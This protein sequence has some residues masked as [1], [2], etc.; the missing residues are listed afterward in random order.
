MDVEEKAKAYDEALKVLHKYDGANI[1]FTQDLKEEMFPEL[2]ESESKDERIRKAI[3]QFFELQDD[4]TTYSL[5]PKKD[6]LVWLEKQGEQKLADK[7]E[8]KFKVGDWVVNNNGEP[9]LFQVTAR[10]WLDSN[11][12]KIKRAKDYFESF[13]NTATL[14]KQYHL[15]TIQDAKDGDV[16][17]CENGWTCIFK[18]LVNDETFSSYCFMDITKWFCETGSE[19]HTL[20]EEFVKAYNGKI[21]PATKEQRDLLF[22]KMKEAGYEWDADKKE[23]R[24]I[25]Q[26]KDMHDKLTAFEF[27]LKHIMEEAI[28]CGDTHNLKADADMLLRLVQKPWSGKDEQILSGIIGYLC[29]HDSCELEGFDE[30]YDWLKSLKDRIQ[31]QSQQEWSEEDENIRLRLIDYLYGK[32]RL[33]KDREDGISW[34]KSIKDRVQPQYLTI[35][36]EEL[37]KAR[38][39]AYN[40]A[41]DKLEYHSDTPT[42]NDGWSAAIWYLK[43]RTAQP[44]NTWKPSDEQITW[45]YRAADDASKDSRM[46]Q[47]L[48]E[49]LS[50]L[51]KL[52]GEL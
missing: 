19:C 16:L 4:N 10:S 38:N 39:E 2:K 24:K 18:T 7:I 3:I 51:K 49:L 44:H 35:T 28:E 15:W 36:D 29:T 8:P 48:N 17:C 9:Q 22:Q 33:A 25:E 46:K 52:K 40:D 27:S 45:L 26:K 42:F 47:V 31:P 6:I 12:S 43:K 5:I 34:L 1:M 50:D 13:I 23:L 14:D 41:L 20:K 11:D 32:S 37:I 30:W 21:H